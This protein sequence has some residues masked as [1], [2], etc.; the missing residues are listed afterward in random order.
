M[1]ASKSFN[2]SL[3]YA[4]M[5]KLEEHLQWQ[6]T[7]KITNKNP[8]KNLN[9]MLNEPNLIMILFKGLG[10]FDYRTIENPKYQKG[11]GNQE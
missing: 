4:E 5:E 10:P 7:S 2:G 9:N 8:R 3:E 11:F 6:Q 1:S